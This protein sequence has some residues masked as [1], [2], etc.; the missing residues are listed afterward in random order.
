MTDPLLLLLLA[1]L[2][3][4]LAATAQAMTGFGFALV[5]VPLLS[6]LYDP[7][8]VVMV[9][10]SLGMVSR[11]PLLAQ[12]WR[13]VELIRIAPL[14]LTSIVGSVGGT[15]LLLRVDGSALR[16]GI[17]L[18]VIALAGLLLLE[19]RR[20]A[21][22]EGLAA[23]AAGLVSGALNGA[24]AMGGPPVVLL[25]VNQA[26]GKENFRANLLAYFLVSQGGGVA[27]LVLAGAFTPAVLELDAKLLPGLVAGLA[28]GSV[29]FK[30][31][32]ADRFRRLVVLLVIATGLLSVWTGGTSLLRFR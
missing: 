13:Q 23:L 28:L 11:L 27:L 32:P 14:C 15:Q 22:R 2:I 26:W 10:L 4:C 24:T 3:V 9:S 8:I 16:L 5:L 6:V 18:V 1:S 17:G 21:R 25:G 30:V 12:S 31:V 29:L 19:K 20:P 7:R